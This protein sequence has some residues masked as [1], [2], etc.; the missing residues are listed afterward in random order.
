MKAPVSLSMMPGSKLNILKNLAF[1]FAAA[2]KI[3]EIHVGHVGYRKCGLRETL[4]LK[5]PFSS[6]YS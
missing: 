4:D 6:A 5:D 3:T 2:M 1:I